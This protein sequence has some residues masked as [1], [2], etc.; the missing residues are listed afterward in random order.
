M[1][2]IGRVPRARARARAR[3]DEQANLSR[4]VRVHLSVWARQ[5]RGW[6]AYGGPERR[7]G[8]GGEVGSGGRG[9]SHLLAARAPH[10]PRALARLAREREGQRPR[11]AA[12]RAPG[13]IRAARPAEAPVRPP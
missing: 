9:V 8:D 11:V 6:G 10:G 5:G 13:T 2:H 7:S 3:S 12:P 4:R 1:V